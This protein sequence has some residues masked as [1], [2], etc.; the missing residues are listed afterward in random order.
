MLEVISSVTENVLMALYQ[1]FWF[2]LAMSVMT[3]FVYLFATD[4]SSAGHGIIESIRVWFRYFKAVKRFSLL[5]YFVF[6]SSLIL[7]RTLINRNMWLN[8][9]SNIMGGWSMYTIDTTTGD[10]KLTTEGIE[11]IILFLQFSFFLIWLKAKT[12]STKYILWFGVKY[13]FIASLFI[14][15]LQV[16]LRVGSFQFSDLFYNT[17]GG[18][19][20]GILFILFRYIDY[21][22]CKEK[23]FK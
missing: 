22:V 12:K 5:F 9:L 18:F 13:V 10:V 3:M 6:Y 15:L 17:I 14:E 1:P 4:Q 19:L 16:F 11:N 8:P 21:K 20:G 2:A 7:F 23:I